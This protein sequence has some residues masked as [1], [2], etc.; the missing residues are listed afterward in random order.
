[1]GVESFLRE[2]MERGEREVRYPYLTY[3]LFFLFSNPNPER[4]YL[5]KEGREISVLDCSI[6]MLQY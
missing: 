5:G 1:M 4:R 2:R 3:E 6:D